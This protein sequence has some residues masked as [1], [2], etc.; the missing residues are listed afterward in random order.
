MGSVVQR[1]IV[2]FHQDEHDDWVAELACG[3]GQHVRHKPPFTLRPWTLTSE[4]RAS[5][6]GQSL[7]CV[8]CDRLELPAGF[9]AYR[10]T[11][12]FTENTVPKGLLS[13]H[14]TKAGVWGKLEVLSG[15]MTYVLESQ[16]ERGVVVS[17][18]GSQLIAPEAK[19]HVE[20]VGPV[21][22]TVEF[23]RAPR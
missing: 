13:T 10:K 4:G 15:A 17:A 16:P 14:G 19:H 11:Q 21:E 9:E 7:D 8:R 5:R 12:I 18:G 3:H 20:V 1:L 2:G 23:F 22:F 6:V